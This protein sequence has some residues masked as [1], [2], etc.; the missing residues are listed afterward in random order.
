[1]NALPDEWDGRAGKLMHVVIKRKIVDKNAMYGDFTALPRVPLCCKCK[2][3]FNYS[4]RNGGNS[5]EA[6]QE[7]NDLLVKHAKPTL[8]A[9]ATDSQDS[10]T[11]AHSSNAPLRVLL[12]LKGKVRNMVGIM[13]G[14]SELAGRGARGPLAGAGT[15]A[16]PELWYGRDFRRQL[17]TYFKPELERPSLSPRG[18]RYPMG[19][20]VA[21]FAGKETWYPGTIAAS[22]ENNTYD[23]RYDN[24]DIAQHVFPHM[25]RFAPIHRDSRLLCFYYGLALISAM[26]WPLAGFGYLS[27]PTSDS[28]AGSAT[29]G[30]LV[31]T[32]ALALGVAGVWAVMAQFGVIYRE[33]KSAGLPMTLRYAVIVA[34]PSASLALVGGTTMAK[35]S[36]PSSAGSWVE[37]SPT[38]R[39][40]SGCCA[41]SEQKWASGQA[42]GRR[43]LNDK[44]WLCMEHKE[45]EK[46]GGDAV[47]SDM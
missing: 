39:L 2:T 27:E 32:P 34:L 17:K 46:V 36:N 25:V 47:S 40:L 33:N 8:Q 26:A 28:E 29:A 30:T 14:A 24:G 4:W 35:V 13:R 7:Q 20:E 11:V 3:P 5:D 12:G 45:V 43:L 6:L 37:V 18:G 16:Q 31:A 42:R 38:Y 22:R 9:T 19:T 41:A 23:V 44:I 21:C 1:M 10:G 15:R